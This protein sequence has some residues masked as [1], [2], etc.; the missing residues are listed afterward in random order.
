MRVLIDGVEV[1]NAA[2]NPTTLQIFATRDGETAEIQLIGLSALDFATPDDPFAGAWMG[3]YWPNTSFLDSPIYRADPTIDFD[4]G[5]G[6]AFPGWPDAFCAR[7][8]RLIPL[9]A[10]VYR[11]SAG[12]DDGMRVYVDS[13]LLI[14]DWVSSAYNVVTYDL[15]ITDPRDY[16]FIV[17]YYDGGGAGRATFSYT[18]IA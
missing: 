7:W 11:L 6:P 5:T 2:V 9:E 15:T 8:E 3:Q 18:K 4:W 17:E 1:Y 13:A 12:S 16:Y 10:G 14:N